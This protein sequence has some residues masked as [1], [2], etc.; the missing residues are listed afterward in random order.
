MQSLD[1][2]SDMHMEETGWANPKWQQCFLLEGEVQSGSLLYCYFENLTELDFF[3][4]QTNE[5]YA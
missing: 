5:I 2:K 4:Q 3:S 1:C